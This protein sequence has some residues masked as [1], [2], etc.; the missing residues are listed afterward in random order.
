MRLIGFMNG[1]RLAPHCWWRF[2]VS[3][4]G[5]DITLGWWSVSIVGFVFFFE[6]RR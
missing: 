1:W 3:P 4:I 2:I 6:R 5:W